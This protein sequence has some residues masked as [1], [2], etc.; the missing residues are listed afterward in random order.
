MKL[1][2]R[3]ANL[4]L[5]QIVDQFGE[6]YRALCEASRAAFMAS[7]RGGDRI[8]APGHI[9]GKEFGEQFSAK[10]REFMDA[11]AAIIDEQTAVV[12]EKL[13]EAPSTE[14]VNTVQLLA[15]RDE[16]TEEEVDGLLARY[17]ENAQVFKAIVSVSAAKGLRGWKCP[18]DERLEDLNGLLVTLRRT[19]TLASAEAGHASEG[20][21]AMVKMQ[22]NSALPAS[23]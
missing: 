14:A 18:L 23:R 10:C 1:D 5:Q 7:L 22:I 21:L 3:G 19:F 16:L 6:T 9:Y 15:L 13:V 11:A 17:G 12:R 20:Y 2:T 4:R 8:P